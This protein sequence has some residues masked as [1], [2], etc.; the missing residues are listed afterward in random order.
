MERTGIAAVAVAVVALFSVTWATG[1]AERVRP[2]GGRPTILIEA[3]T[4]VSP[5]DAPDALAA[6][7]AAVDAYLTAEHDRQVAE[8]L[9]AV[10]AERIERERIAAAARTARP[11]TPTSYAS[12]GAGSHDGDIAACIR[13]HEGWYE[14]NTGNGFYGAYQFVIGTWRSVLSRMGPEYAQWVYVLPSDAPPWVQD[15][16]FWTLWAGGAGARNWPVASRLCG[17]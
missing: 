8:Y 15:A 3:V 7:G 6:A 14:A 1:T 9:A 11:Q 12:S 5:G 13:S 10:E 2:A 16:A 17:Y 4:A